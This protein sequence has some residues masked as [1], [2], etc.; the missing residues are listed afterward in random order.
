VNI[1]LYTAADRDEWERMRSALWPEQDATELG[2]WLARGDAVVLVA[3]AGG[4]RLSGFA[5]V[6]ERSTADGCDT[7]PVAY[8]EGW[9]VDAD[10]RRQGIGAA[11]AAAAEEWARARGHREF[12]SDTTLDNMI[13]QAA[14]RRLGFTEVERAVLYRKVLTPDTG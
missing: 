11:L 8:L 12:A 1:R 10:C 2:V 5:E 9:W 7:S 4:G 6:G 3:D 13:S 14:H